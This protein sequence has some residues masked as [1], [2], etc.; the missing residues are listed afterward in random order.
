MKAGKRM[1]EEGA[2]ILLSL[3]TKKKRKG[4]GHKTHSFHQR[5]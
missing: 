3:Q 5:E 4:V 2:H 1:K